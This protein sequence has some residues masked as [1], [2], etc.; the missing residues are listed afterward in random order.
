MARTDTVSL[1]TEALNVIN[2]ALAEHAESM[3]YQALI[4]ASEKT[5]AD[6][7]IGVAVYAS[8]SG[9]VFDYFTI[10]YRDRSFELV[11]RGK[12]EPEVSWKVSRAYLEEVAENPRDY[13]E[14]PLKLDWDWLKSRLG[15]EL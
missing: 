1:F 8:D 10:R 13:I 14:N 9:S 15:L 2:A 11:S 12:E 4:D 6:R 5:L 3:P 7:N